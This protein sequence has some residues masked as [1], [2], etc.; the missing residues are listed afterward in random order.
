M[1][2]VETSSDSSSCRFAGAS[3]GK[4]GKKFGFSSFWAMN[5]MFGKRWCRCGGVFCGIE[6]GGGGAA[7]LGGKKALNPVA[8]IGAK[9]GHFDLIKVE[10]E[11]LIILD[12]NREF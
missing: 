5:L 10:I 9:I 7:P 1:F 3:G 4:L 8:V 6:G 11:D 12:K 2:E